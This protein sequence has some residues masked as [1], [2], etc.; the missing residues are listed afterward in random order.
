ML[1]NNE[2]GEFHEV[3]RAARAIYWSMGGAIVIYVIV[4]EILKLALKPF[5]GFAVGDMPDF[6][7]FVFYAIGILA[8]IPGFKLRKNVFHTTTPEEYL[9]LD[10]SAL[11]R[12]FN[13]T[14]IISGALAG[15]PSII[16]LVLFLL[17][18]SSA[19]FYLMVLI[20]VISYILFYPRESQ[21]RDAMKIPPEL[22]H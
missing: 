16:G 8:V 18:G 9:D 13:S 11:L 14:T 7:P 10:M 5:E 6:I 1:I 4:A 12:R 2:G 22:L 17:T 3:Y 19:D 15:L 20:S 21:W